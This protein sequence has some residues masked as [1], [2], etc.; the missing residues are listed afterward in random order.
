[1]KRQKFNTLK[2]ITAILSLL[3]FLIFS[4]AA[5]TQDNKRLGKVYFKM[6]CTTCHV[7]AS[8]QAIPP[9][10]R[11]MNEWRQYLDNN[12]HDLKGQSNHAVNYYTSKDYRMAIKDSNKAAKKFLKLDGEKIYGDV[13]AFLISGAKDSD[14]PASCE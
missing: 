2:S 11:T 13:K 7:E 1:M 14:T 12:Q 4:T 8:G 10:T 6:V 3:L 9:N 5:M